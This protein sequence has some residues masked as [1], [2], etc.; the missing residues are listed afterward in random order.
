MR[1]YKTADEYEAELRE[2][3]GLYTERMWEGFKQDY[4]LC[5]RVKMRTARAALKKRTAGVGGVALPASIIQGYRKENK[6]RQIEFKLRKAKLREQESK[7]RKHDSTILQSPTPT[8]PE[9]ARGESYEDEDDM[10]IISKY[11]KGS[12]ERGKV[13]K[14]ILQRGYVTGGVTRSRSTL[15]KHVKKFEDSLRIK[16]K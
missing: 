11:P 12:S 16:N 2:F 15:Y 3:E 13:I 8:I 10:K 6:R 4:K 7:N 5:N 9:P 1:H 14:L